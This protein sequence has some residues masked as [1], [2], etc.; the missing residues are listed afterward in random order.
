MFIG[1]CCWAT[2]E[3]N[4]LRR[5]ASEILQ[6]HC[7]LPAHWDIKGA[8]L[9][10]ME[11]PQEIVLGEARVDDAKIK[12]FSAE[13]LQNHVLSCFIVSVLQP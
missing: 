10:S 5:V 11:S 9:R 13:T 7:C 4:F 1:L 3:I 2:N 12:H 6:S 8:T